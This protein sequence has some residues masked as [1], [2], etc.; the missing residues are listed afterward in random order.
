MGGAENHLFSALR[1][2]GFVH[3]AQLFDT[4]FF[5]ASLAEAAAMDPQ[6][7]LLLERGYEALHAAWLDRSALGGSLTGVHLGITAHEF[8]GVLAAS[9][10]SASVYAATGSALSIASGRLSYVLGLHGACAAYDSA[11]SA[12][13]VSL[14]AGVRSLQGGE[15]V[16]CLAEG[17]NLMLS[18][19]VGVGFC[20]AGM[21]SPVGRSH[22]FDARA[23]GFARGEGCAAVALAPLDGNVEGRAPNAAVGGCAVR[24]DGRSA[25]LTA[26]NGQAQ[27]G[28]LRASLADAATSADSFGAAEAHGT[29]TALGDPIEAGSLQGAVVSG[30]TGLCGPMCVGGVKAN[31]GHAEP[32]AGLTGL[33]RLVMGM[34]C[35]WAPPNA[36]LRALNPHVGGLKAGSG[37][38]LPTQVSGVGGGDSGG[39]SSFGYSGTI[40]H[41]VMCSR[42]AILT[43]AAPVP[44]P[45]FR[46]RPYSWHHHQ[47]PLHPVEGALALYSMCWKSVAVP[48]LPAASPT[49]LYLRRRALPSGISSENTHPR[50]RVAA[51]VLTEMSEG[52]A[53]SITSCQVWLSCMRIVA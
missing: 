19:A 30:R 16:R 43:Y 47:Q 37:S 25:S 50:A 3:G 6:Q 5:S 35:G 8:E 4:G 32:A 27:Q 45:R 12:A 44:A 46:R 14:H 10:A 48:S 33:V 38:V 34:E 42:G 23:D 11:C 31:I 40:A 39:V 17:V 53:P 49:V 7:R 15:C 26:P 9:P 36:Q 13:L 24:C 29:G 28:L 52:N 20:F 21:T 1:Y 18:P 51:V 2:G 41:A 22:T